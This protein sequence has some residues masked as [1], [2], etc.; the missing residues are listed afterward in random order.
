MTDYIVVMKLADAHLWPATVHAVK[1]VSYFAMPY[2]SLITSLQGAQG[3]RNRISF[4]HKSHSHTTSFFLI[5]IS[6]KLKIPN[7]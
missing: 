7:S 1:H 2:Y 4:S 5:F 6:T 3:P